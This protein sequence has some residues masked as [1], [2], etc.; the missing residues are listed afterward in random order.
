MAL[1]KCTHCGASLKVASATPGKKFKCPKC[2]KVFAVEAEKEPEVEEPIEQEEERE[3]E[4]APKP[5][6]PAKPVKKEEDEEPED[7]EETDDEEEAP[8]TKGKPAAT[9]A[10][11]GDGD[12]PKKKSPAFLLVLIG[13]LLLFCCGSVGYTAF[14]F[15][16]T[17]KGWVGLGAATGKKLDTSKGTNVPIKD[18]GN[19]EKDPGPTPD[20]VVVANE[21]ASEF[22]KNFQAAFKKNINKIVE[23]EGEVKGVA[24]FPVEKKVGVIIHAGK[25]GGK[26]Y[27]LSFIPKSE[28]I[29][30]IGRLSTG[31]KVKAVGKFFTH[32][33]E[34]ISFKD[35]VI[36]EVGKSD[37]EEISAAVFAAE[38]EKDLVAADNKYRAKAFLLSAQVVEVAKM[39]ETG[40]LVA[41][42]IGSA[43]TGIKL[44]SNTVMVQQIEKLKAGEKALIRVEDFTYLL[45]QNTIFVTR[46]IVVEPE[47][48]KTP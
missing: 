11:K 7:K 10:K 48:G 36:T 35:S 12:A 24:Y 41:T 6:K 15:L 26:N 30:V 19:E 42:L 39:K 23:T 25:V 22:H 27:Q 3:E 2:A 40:P 37:I 31:Q 18:G 28:D 17:I 34:N 4:E 45:Q 43:K 32:V 16:E 21:F 13:I 47:A 46:A 33:G 20:L 1:I 8:K 38:I 14:A 9:P 29:K 44:D 5:K